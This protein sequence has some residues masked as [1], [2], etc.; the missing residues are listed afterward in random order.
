MEEAEQFADQVATRLK[1]NGAHARCPGGG[2]AEAAARGRDLP[3]SVGG[4][5]HLPARL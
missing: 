5:G 3:G 4:F 1:T 2:G